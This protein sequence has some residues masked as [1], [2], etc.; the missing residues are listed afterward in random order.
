MF[1]ILSSELQNRIPIT[2][3]LVLASLL[4]V[5][6]LGITAVIQVLD[7]YRMLG[8]WLTR[9]VSASTS[10]I[11]AL[12]QDI[13]ARIIVWSLASV[14]LLLCTL[15]TLW[16]QQRQLAI[17][18]TLHQVRQMAHDILSFTARRT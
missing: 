8:N 10:D 14:V 4:L 2:V 17:R 9:P 6:V 18:R 1:S 3:A 12:R 16:L 11:R 13:G 15:A 5:F 7:E